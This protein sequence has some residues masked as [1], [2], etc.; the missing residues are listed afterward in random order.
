MGERLVCLHGFTGGRGDFGGLGRALA[1]DGIELVAFDLPG[2]GGEGILDGAT[3]ED[4]VR[5]VLDELDRRGLGR[6]VHLAG[7]SQG[8]R[9]ALAA[10]VEEPARFASLALVSATAGIEDAAERRDRRHRDEELAERIE[11]DGLAAFVDSWLALP[12]FTGRAGAGHRAEWNRRQSRLAGSARGYA[13]A[14]RAFG[15]GSQPSLWG[16]LGELALPVLVVAGET[17]EKYVQIAQ[18][19]GSALARGTVEIVSGVGHGVVD[20]APERLAELLVRHI[21]G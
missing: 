17:D 20:E 3:F 21:R 10:A 13:R 9:L 12:L 7:Y 16:R 1:R 15:Q 19:L 14:L 18:R 4:G 2:H 11:R 6:D 8:G 5:W